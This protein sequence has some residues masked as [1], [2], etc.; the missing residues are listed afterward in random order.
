MARGTDYSIMAQARRLEVLAAIRRLQCELDAM[1]TEVL[2]VIAAD[3]QPYRDEPPDSGKKWAREDVACAL[4]IPPA[5]AR[6][7][8]E[9]ARDTVTRFPD[10]L[11][12]MWATQLSGPMAE[13]LVESCT[14]LADSPARE[15]E[16]RVL[17]HC[18]TQTY[19]QFGRSVRRAV[20]AADTRLTEASTRRRANTA[21]SCSP[22]SST[23]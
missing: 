1:R 11:D 5:T 4:R 15:V 21:G 2:A 7:H 19:S 17:K 8:L 9:I 16:A 6:H 20:A 3:P 12:A 22:T 18:G 13:R 14:D 23:A 10:T